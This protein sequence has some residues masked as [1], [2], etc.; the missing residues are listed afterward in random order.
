[1]KGF[2]AARVTCYWCADD[3]FA[4]QISVRWQ[5]TPFPHAVGVAFCVPLSV[6]LE[7]AGAPV[8]PASTNLLHVPAFESVLSHCQLLDVFGPRA[9]VWLLSHDSAKPVS[10]TVPALVPHVTG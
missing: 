8:T 10:F 1:M 2:V 4:I 5:G 7:F 9:R 3:I 6:P